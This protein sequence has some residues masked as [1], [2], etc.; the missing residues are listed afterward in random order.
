MSA[1][2]KEKYRNIFTL[3]FA[4]WNI[5][6]FFYNE[7]GECIWNF[8]AIMDNRTTVFFFLMDIPTKILSTVSHDFKP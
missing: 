1:K 5:F 4:E 2:E 7:N 8:L 6:T 3:F